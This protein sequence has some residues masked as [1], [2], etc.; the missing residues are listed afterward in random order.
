MHL[1]ITFKDAAT[2]AIKGLPELVSS[3]Q[4]LASGG[5][6]MRDSIIRNFGSLGPN[7]RFPNASTGFWGR[8]ALSTTAPVVDG[9]S[10]TVSITQIGVR[11]RYLGGQISAKQ[12]KY[13]TIP[14]QEEAYGKRAREFSDLSV[15]FMGRSSS[16]LPIFAL[17][18]GN[19]K[20]SGKRDV[21]FWLVAS[22]NQE[23]DESTLPTIDQLRGA[24]AG[25]IRAFVNARLRKR[26]LTDDSFSLPSGNPAQS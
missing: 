13:L 8:A 7:K 5:M 19:P 2:A 9:N 23:G 11:Q 20:I 10:A 25:G 26:V 16:G 12:G 14:A 1:T 18:R 3:P 15:S 4:A 22:V 24:F 17:V 6:K 21:M